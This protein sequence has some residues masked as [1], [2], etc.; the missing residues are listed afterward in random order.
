VAD[1]GAWLLAACG[2]AVVGIGVF[3]VA[4]R[5]SLLPEDRRYIAAPRETLD[6]VRPA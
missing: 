3:F 6:A 4:L 5:R 1:V 2:L